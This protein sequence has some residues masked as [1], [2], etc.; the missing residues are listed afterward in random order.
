MN[1]ELRKRLDNIKKQNEEL[2]EREFLERQIKA[3][4]DK[5]VQRERSPVVKILLGIAKMINEFLFGK[6]KK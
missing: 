1:D 2:Q 5:L 6:P 3:E 4:Q